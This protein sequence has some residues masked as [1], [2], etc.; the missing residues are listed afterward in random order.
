MK[1]SLCTI[2]L[3]P[4]LA[5]S[6]L[7][8][9]QSAD[10]SAAATAAETA[11]EAATEVTTEKTAE[12][13]TTEAAEADAG[14]AF[15]VMIEHAFGSTTIESQPENVAVIGWATQD[16]VLAL[17]KVPVGMSAITFGPTNDNGL[18]SWEQDALDG[19]GASSINIYDDTDGIDFEAVSDSAPDVILAPYSGLSQEDYDTL[20][21]IAPTIAYSET[22]WKCDWRTEMNVTAKALGM[23]DA[24]DEVISSVE[25]AIQD[26]V[27]AHPEIKG[28]KAVFTWITA[29]DLSSINVYN[30]EDPREQFLSDLSLAQPDYIQN[31]SN[32]SNFFETVSAENAVDV[33][34]DADVIL[35]YGDDAFLA[36]VQADPLLG[37]IPAIAKGNVVMMDYD[38]DVYAASSEPTVLS[39][40]A[41]VDT[42]VGM[43][44]DAL[45]K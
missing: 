36:Q 40:P 19:L 42:Y 27:D 26:A 11:P 28:K 1:K 45:A 21:Q 33:L 18:Y 43:I 2:A 20:R 34:S 24:G 14:D 16:A 29:D 6:M 30:L 17:G 13:G 41:T 22:A 32:P 3:V 5:A 8:G 7:V 10:S 37:K 4:A 9:C 15:P 35:T 44:A 12:A 31:L 39:I 38:T 23:E 25:S